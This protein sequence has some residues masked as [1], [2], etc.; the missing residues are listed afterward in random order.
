[1]TV[2]DL[3]KPT[4]KSVTIVGGRFNIH[5]D[6]L[7]W[8][9]SCCDG[10]GIQKFP[11]PSTNKPFTYLYFTRACAAIMGCESLE[12]EVTKAMERIANAQIHSEDVRALWLLNNPPDEDMQKFLAEHVAIRI[13]E[14]RLKAKGAY[15]TLREEIPEFNRAIDEI[16]ALKKAERKSEKGAVA[17][18]EDNKKPA[19][20]RRRQEE[21]RSSNPQNWRATVVSRRAQNPKGE[22]V[23][24]GTIK[25]EVVKTGKIRAEVVRRGSNGRPTFARLDLE[26]LGVTKDGFRGQTY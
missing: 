12:K 16:L 5:K 26:D 8:M 7:A 19:P 18:V 21:W 6:I 17:Q 20:P 1:M 9:S 10:R 11:Y 15:T 13:W 23:N 2:A 24:T 3:R 22:D 4:R 25:A 14:K